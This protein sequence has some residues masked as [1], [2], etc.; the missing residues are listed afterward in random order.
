MKFVSDKLEPFKEKIF[1]IN[2]DS[3][4]IVLMK[5]LDSKYSINNYN[6]SQVQYKK[7]ELISK[8]INEGTKDELKVGRVTYPEI[9]SYSGYIGTQYA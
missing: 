5:K 3:G 4:H 9:V 6:S 1:R 7:E 8:M 2:P